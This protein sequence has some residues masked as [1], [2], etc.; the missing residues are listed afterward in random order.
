MTRLRAGDRLV[1]ASHNPGKVREIV[2][3]LAPLG[4]VPVGA[5]ELGLAQPAETGDTFAANATL[6]AR[7]A[8]DATGLPALA[9]DSGLMIA[10]LGGQPGVHTARWAGPARDYAAA[11]ARIERELAGRADRR[12]RFVATLALALPGGGVDL[13]E[14]TVDGVLVSPPRGANGFGYDPVFEPDG[15]GRTFA[16]MAP[17]EK[18]RFNHRARAFA[19]LV[20]HLGRA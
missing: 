4:V 6:K 13:F 3:L 17:E 2:D 9:D 7:A 12:A 11:F 16:E 14:G 19:K 1:V 5:S 15:E 8:A 10:A 18:R 20:A